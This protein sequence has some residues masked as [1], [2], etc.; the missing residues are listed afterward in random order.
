[1]IKSIQ[2]YRTHGIGEIDLICDYCSVEF[3]RLK[4]KFDRSTPIEAQKH[5]CCHTCWSQHHKTLIKVSCKRCRK[6]IFRNPK[7]RNLSG[8]YFCSPSC[9][10]RYRIENGDKPGKQKLNRKCRKCSNTAQSGSYYCAEHRFPHRIDW[11]TIT[12]KEAQRK[13]LNKNS[14]IRENAKYVCKD[15]ICRNCGYT[16][17]VEICHIRGI[18]TFSD[19]TLVK[20]INDPSNL[21]GLCPNCHWEL[22]NGILSLD[23]I[24]CPDR[25]C[26]YDSELSV[27]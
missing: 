26:T 11:E 22:D 20:V 4:R 19:D 14:K 3:K 21:I 13:G 24:G 27:Q 5:F 12:Y 16:K 8:N 25:T 2:Q 1:M 18:S 23:F 15:T 10:I 17:H 7:S 9:C 6:S